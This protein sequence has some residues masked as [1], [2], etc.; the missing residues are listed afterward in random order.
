MHGCRSLVFREWTRTLSR[1][2]ARTVGYANSSIGRTSQ[3]VRDVATRAGSLSGASVDCMLVRRAELSI[4]ELAKTS[5]A[6][7][8]WTAMTLPMDRRVPSL[9]LDSWHIEE[10]SVRRG[11]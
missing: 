7:F 6:T 2:V 9:E 1:L 8:S 11:S 10:E 5:H 3:A 4:A